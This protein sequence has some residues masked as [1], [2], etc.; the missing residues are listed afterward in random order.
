[1]SQVAVPIILHSLTLPGGADTFWK[2]LDEDYNDEDWR[3][4][5]AAVEKT[6]LIFR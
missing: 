2:M 5:F 1:M 4:R 3:V 6:T